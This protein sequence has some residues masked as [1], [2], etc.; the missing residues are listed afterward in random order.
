MTVLKPDEKLEFRISDEGGGF[1]W[2]NYIDL[3][4]D[5]ARDLHGRG[6]ALAN[7]IS[8]DSLTYEDNGATA[9]ATVPIVS[10]K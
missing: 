4:P 10:T 1:G 7:K 9:I 3:E 5:R 6:I 2:Q 8:F